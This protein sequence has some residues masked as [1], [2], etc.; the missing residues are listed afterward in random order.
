MGKRIAAVDRYIAKAAPFARA[1]LEELRERI[2]DACP[3]VGESIKWGHVSFGYRGMLGGMA[4]FKQH[5]A[6]GFWKHA[7]LVKDP[8]LPAE[9]KRDAMGSFGRMKSVDDLPSRRVFTKLVKMAMKLNAEDVKNPARS[10][11]KPKA[12][13]KPPAVFVA[14]L[15]KNKRAVA[16]WEAFA[17]SHKR[18][19][20]E[21]ITEAKTDE[22]RDRRI[23]TTVEWVAEGKQRMWKYQKK[24]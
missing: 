17:P 20:L 22:T 2:H 24:K 13:I 6:F 4:A 14:A 21:W 16:T 9:L 8:A 3:E 10:N 23:A 1:I 7:L 15:E 12:A 5:A 19:Y 11:P 18:E